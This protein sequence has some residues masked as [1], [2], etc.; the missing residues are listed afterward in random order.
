MQDDR[1]TAVLFRMSHEA[2]AKLQ[3]EAAELNISVQALLERRALGQTDAVTRYGAVRPRSH[4]D[5]QDGL[6]LTG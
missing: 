1:A 3:R 2:K 4:N 5:N 6:P